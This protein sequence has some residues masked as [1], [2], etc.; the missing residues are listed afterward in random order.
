MSKIAPVRLT[1]VSGNP[2]GVAAQPF[3]VNS[4]GIAYTAY[5][6]KTFTITGAQTNYAVKAGQ[7]MFAV[8]RTTV[9]VKT[10]IACTVRFGVVGNSAISLAAGEQFTMDKFSVAD[11]FVT[12]TGDTILRVV[13]LS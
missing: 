5:E 9:L 6:A 2:T 13:A 12:T 3:V 8:P 1:D 11:L 10:D 7:S 4:Q